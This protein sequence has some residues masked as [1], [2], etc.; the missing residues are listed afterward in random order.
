MRKLLFLAL[1]LISFSSSASNL[2][3]ASYTFTPH[4]TSKVAACQFYADFQGAN[5][6]NYGPYTSAIVQDG[7]P[8]KCELYNT[9][10]QKVTTQNIWT[11]VGSTC[12]D[13]TEDDGTGFC[14]EV[15]TCP[16]AGTTLEVLVDAVL[17][18]NTMSV[19]GC[20]ATYVEGSQGACKLAVD[21]STAVCPRTVSFT[22]EEGNGDPDANLEGVTYASSNDLQQST[23]STT[24]SDGTP[25][26]DGSG[27]V[28]D[29][30]SETT[31]V[32]SDSGSRIYS[33]DNYIYVESS[34]GTVTTY[35]KTIT[36]VTQ[37]DGSK[38]EVISIDKTVDT[39]NK[40]TSIINNSTGAVTTI[41][42]SS[43]SVTYNET[44]TN[45]YDTSGQLTDSSSTQSGSDTGSSD[46]G[47]NPNDTECGDSPS[48]AS[49]DKTGLY[50]KTDKTFGSVLTA[51]TDTIQATQLFT[52]MDGFFDV[53]VS[54]TCPIWN[55]P[56][57]WVFPPIIV[58]MQC[59]AVMDTLLLVV[60]AIMIASSGFMAFRWAV[61]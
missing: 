36:E 11:F 19:N 61:L 47:C 54:G 58:D 53:N 30:N 17:A 8:A 32:T 18:E 26:T 9:L 52:A 5:D 42:S 44:I 39:P 40:E 16:D 50:E 41:N 34:D 14:A 13:G 25:S 38:Q 12:P 57:V 60:M 22:G 59:S 27:V 49:S 56:A 43:E 4:Q 29:T 45:N 15:S 46:E 37:T 48:F 10:N 6:I 3:S 24:Y 51:F 1:F 20:E 2:Y 55:L 7:D 21:G 35:Q 31:I 33:D 28:T 23:S